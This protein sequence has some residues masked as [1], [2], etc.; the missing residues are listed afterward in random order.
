MPSLQIHRQ[1]GAQIY[2]VRLYGRVVRLGRVDKMAYEHA[3]ERFLEL[4]AQDLVLHPFGVD[5][6][7]RVRTTGEIYRTQS[8][9][10]RGDHNHSIE[11]AG[12]L[13]LPAA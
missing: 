13:E 1:A 8:Y 5:P 11:V 12:A 4:A 2:F 6:I 10:V 7:R 9:G 3:Y